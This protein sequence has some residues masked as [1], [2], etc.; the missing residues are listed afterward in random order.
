MGVVSIHTYI[1]TLHDSAEARAHLLK[2]Y[3]LA[4]LIE[5]VMEEKMGLNLDLPSLSKSPSLFYKILLSYI[6]NIYTYIYIYPTLRAFFNYGQGEVI[7]QTTL[8]WT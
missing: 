5:K 6:K 3:L 1:S 4:L 7:I 2:F 8:Y